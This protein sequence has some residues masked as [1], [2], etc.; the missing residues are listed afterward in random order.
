MSQKNPNSFLNRTKRFLLSRWS[1]RD[2]PTSE[3]RFQVTLF[4]Q[5]VFVFI[6]LPILSIFIYKYV[7]NLFTHPKKPIRKDIQQNQVVNYEMS[8][9]QILDFQSKNSKLTASLAK[10]ATGTLVKLRL[11]NE[12]ETYG[13]A[14]V[15]AQIIDSSLGVE[16]VGATLIGEAQSDTNFDRINISFNRAKKSSEVG[17]SILIKARALSLNGTLGLEA[18]KKEGYF[19]RSA[20]SSAQAGSQEMNSGAESSDLKHILARALANGL[21]QEFGNSGQVEKNKSQVLVLK[22]GE[23]FFAELIDDFPASGGR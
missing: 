18:N 20:I 17:A 7:E 3:P 2:T 1:E 12:V 23:I 8:K 14:P 11:L 16:W 4:G 21:I 10:R 5:D 22:A 9:S 15:H 19:A 13:S 6:A